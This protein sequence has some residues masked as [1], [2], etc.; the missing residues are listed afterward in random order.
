MKLQEF[1]SSETAA[2]ALADEVMAALRVG[3]GWRERGSLA[4]AGGRTPVA[5]FRLL[6][7]AELDWSRVGITL[8]D[9]RCVPESDPASNAG[10]VRRELLQ[11]RAIDAGFMP[12]VDPRTGAAPDAD[13]VWTRLSHLAQPFDAVVLGMGED[14]HFA[15]LFPGCEG[16][17]AALDAGAAPG[18]VA[19]RSPSAPS[20][21]IS[22]NLAALRQTRRLFLLVTGSAKRQVLESAAA[23]LGEWP[24]RA[25]LTQVEPVAEIYWAP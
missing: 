23:G 20:A 15:S 9:E 14:G 7:Q 18:C 25:L 4:V 11:E 22:L 3:L 8:T 19:M 1:A 24:V 10:L 16:L 17:A 21:R 5:F 13:A 12:L 6:R 2:R